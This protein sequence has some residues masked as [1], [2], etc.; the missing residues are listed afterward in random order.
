MNK[1][2]SQTLA[3]FSLHSIG[4]PAGCWRKIVDGCGSGVGSG[5]WQ[6]KKM[7]N[8]STHRCFST[9]LNLVHCSSNFVFHLTLT[10]CSRAAVT[11]PFNSASFLSTRFNS[12][13]SKIFKTSLV[14][15]VNLLFLGQVF[16][17]NLG[18]AVVVDVHQLLFV[19]FCT[20]R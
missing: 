18:A 4:S 17:L 10:S 9:D 11:R 2:L 19:L 7:H 16:L 15:L 5:S 20:W 3:P 8:R 6:W 14:S 1:T 12:F 13:S